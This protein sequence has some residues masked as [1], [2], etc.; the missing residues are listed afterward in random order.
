MENIN[1]IY[2][3]AMP[4]ETRVNPPFEMGKRDNIFLLFIFLSCIPFTSLGIWGGLNA[5]FTFSV[6]A[7]TTALT[8][9]LG[10]PKNSFRLFPYLSLIFVYIAAAVFT[11]TA[12]SAVR[13]WLFCMIGVLS[14]VWFAY[15][16]GYNISDDASLIS[17]CFTAVFGSAFGS[18]KKSMQTAFSFSKRKSKTVPKVLISLACSVPVVAVL[19]ALLRSGDAAFD[20]LIKYIE[21]SIGNVGEIFV[22]I[23]LGLILLPLMISFCLGLKKSK[24]EQKNFCFKAKIDNAYIVTFISLVC[25]VYITYLFS[26]LAYFFSAFRGILPEGITVASYARRGFF[27]MCTIA[28]VNFVIICLASLFARKNEKGKRNPVVTCLTLFI[29]VF[30]L[31]L[32]AI[33]LSKM[34]LYIQSFG[35]TRLRILT[36]AFMLFL[37]VLFIAVILRIFIRKIPVIKIAVIWASVIL[38]FLGFADVDRTI[39]KYNLYAYESGMV[40][41]LDVYA[42]G[43]LGNG[44]VPVLYEIYQ[45]GSIEQ[46]K[47]AD[48]ELFQDANEMYEV[49]ISE[50]KREYERYREIGDYNISTYKA[51]EVLDEYLGINKK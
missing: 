39:A 6:S 11:F 9:Y 45:N 21:N 20:G 34:V 5:G 12:Q 32:I 46:R 23:L 35:M 8:L 7:F 33:A 4:N 27:E 41:T 24:K 50:S 42:L 36:S 26:Q 10:K 48:K 18:M 19:I 15:Q 2:G 13:F 14:A 49:E 43:D 31:L 3:A 51:Y 38:C 37:A 22:Q 47:Q 25:A 16:R 40:E 17:A 29:G 28:G 44:A 30:T 1:N